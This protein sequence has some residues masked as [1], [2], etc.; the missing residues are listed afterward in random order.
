VRLFYRPFVRWL[1]LGAI[2]MACGGLLAAM[3]K[4]YRQS[5]RAHSAKQSPLV[6]PPGSA[7]EV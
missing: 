3:D 4:R 1:W 7:T 6:V 5:L 2:F